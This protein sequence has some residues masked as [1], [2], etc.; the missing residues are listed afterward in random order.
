MR[1][2]INS[3]KNSAVKARVM[4]CM[5]LIQVDR[6][7]SNSHATSSQKNASW[8]GRIVLSLKR[9]DALPAVMHAGTRIEGHHTHSAFCSNGK[10][11]SKAKGLT[12]SLSCQTM[13][14]ILFPS[15]NTFY[16][17]VYKQWLGRQH[18]TSWMMHFALGTSPRGAN[19]TGQSCLETRNAVTIRPWPASPDLGLR[20]C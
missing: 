18:L 16:S 3:C 7:R 2:Y 19:P 5:P 9:V 1:N 20:K 8:G 6:A 4:T 10:G 17:M 14:G 11:S 15:W 12:P 13:P